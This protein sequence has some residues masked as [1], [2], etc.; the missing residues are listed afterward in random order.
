MLIIVSFKPFV[1]QTLQDLSTQLYL[2]TNLPVKLL[3]ICGFYV[4]TSVYSNIIIHRMSLFICEQVDNFL[5]ISHLKCTCFIRLNLLYFSSC[6]NY[7]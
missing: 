7:D 4:Q 1:Y 2:L 5:N 6:L 3:W